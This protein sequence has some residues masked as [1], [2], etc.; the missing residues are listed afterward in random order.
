MY[1]TFLCPITEE[2]EHGVDESV[3]ENV[4]S[5]NGQQGRAV[6]R[7]NRTQI[8]LGRPPTTYESTDLSEVKQTI[9]S[10]LTVRISKV[11]EIIKDNEMALGG[12]WDQSTQCEQLTLTC[13]VLILI[14]NPIEY[15]N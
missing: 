1:C 9:V 4:N 5:D 13:S 7:Q 14:L 6:E 12:K 2:I 8:P 15:S 11:I 10:S 3:P